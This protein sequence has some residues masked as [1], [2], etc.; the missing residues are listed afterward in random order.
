[1]RPDDLLE[2]CE[3]PTCVYCRLGTRLLAALTEAKVDRSTEMLTLVRVLAVIAV[4]SARSPAA[5]GEMVDGIVGQ[6]R[7]DVA[8][9]T[10]TKET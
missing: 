2:C 6:L 1:M 5:L 9:F 8:L 7:D 4:A 10:G 3:D